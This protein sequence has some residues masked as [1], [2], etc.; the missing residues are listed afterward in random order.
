MSDYRLSDLE[1]RRSA[2]RLGRFFPELDDIDFS[3]K[4]VAYLGTGDQARYPDKF[5]DA[6]GF[7]L[8]ISRRR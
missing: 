8:K 3:C 4:K 1:Y 7:G 5:I 6:M 2:K